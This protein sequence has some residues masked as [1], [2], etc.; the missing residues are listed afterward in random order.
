MSISTAQRIKLKLKDRNAL[1][2]SG[3]APSPVVLY[4]KR[5]NPKKRELAH[6]EATG[7]YPPEFVK[8]RKCNWTNGRAFVECSLPRQ[9]VLRW[10]WVELSSSSEP[11]KV[12][13]QFNGRTILD[14]KIQGRSRFRL[15]LPDGIPRS[16]FTIEISS[17]TFKPSDFVTTFDDRRVLGVLVGEIRVAKYWW[18]NF[19]P[20]HYLRP[21][22]KLIRSLRPR[23]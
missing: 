7:F 6:C 13:L 11:S 22:A 5:N 9:V 10:L 17:P 21:I 2:Q 14:R 4:C 15:R 18:R 19:E 20:R 12:K 3:T 23:K 8:G 1:N 16:R